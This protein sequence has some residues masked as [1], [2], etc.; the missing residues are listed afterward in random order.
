VIHVVALITGFSSRGR[1]VEKVGF[2]GVELA[3]FDALEVRRDDVVFLL[4]IIN[5]VSGVL[6]M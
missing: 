2:A 1:G 6:P 4:A 3:F 5:F